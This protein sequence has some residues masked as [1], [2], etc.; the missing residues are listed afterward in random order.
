M[1]KSYY[2]SWNN[3]LNQFQI[4]F[5]VPANAPSGIIPFTIMS[6]TG[7]YIHSQF[8]QDDQQLRVTSKNVD[9]LG[10]IITSI[11]PFTVENMGIGWE[12]VISDP[13]N[14]FLNGHFQIRGDIDSSVYNITLINN[15]LIKGDIWNGTYKIF[16]NLTSDPCF[17][18]SYTIYS[19]EL[20]DYQFIKSQFSK[21]PS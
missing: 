6:P 10:P 1:Q 8:L 16:I 17:T 7:D 3:S 14:G 19:I 18:Q 12:I 9:V 2:S 5:F 4:E 21:S 15:E 20:N 13:I 11:K